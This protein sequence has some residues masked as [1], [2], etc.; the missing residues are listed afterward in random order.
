MADEYCELCDLPKSQ[1]IHGLPA[2][3]PALKPAARKASP[4]PKPAKKVASPTV[5][6]RPRRWTPPEAIRPHV[7]HVLREAGGE[8]EAEEVFKRLEDRMA[9]SLLDADQER[10][11]E[12]ELRWRFAARKARQALIVEGLMAKSRPGLWELTSTGLADL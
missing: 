11:P 3:T 4:R 1:C 2:P 10:T 7:L 5:A 6:A 8:L 12:G 9:D